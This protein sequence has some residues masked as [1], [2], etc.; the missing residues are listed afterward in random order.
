[1]VATWLL[2][3]RR[4][5]SATGS[6]PR[7]RS[8]TVRRVSFA[9]SHKMTIVVLG[10]GVVGSSIAYHLALAG[11]SCTIIEQERPAAG[12]SGKAGGFLAATW[13]DGRASE[14]LHRK[15]Y[16]MHAELAQRLN[17]Q[18]Y[19]K[20]KTFRVDYCRR[21]G[22]PVVP[23]LDADDA[24]ASLLDE[25]TAQV[26]PAELSAALLREALASGLCELRIGE[27]IGVEFDEQDGTAC[28]SVQLQ[29]GDEVACQSVVVAMGPWS[30]RVEDWFGVPLPLEGV[31]STSIVYEDVGALEPAALFVHEDMRG[32][33]LEI[34]P[35][36]C[37]DIYVSGCGGSRMVTADALRR[38]E[39][40]PAATNDPDM[41]RV[42]AAERSLAELT[43]KVNRPSDKQQACLRP[44]SPDG[45]PIMGRL[46]GMQNAYVAAG[47]NAWGILLAPITGLAM[48]QL[49]LEGESSVVNLKP[50]RPHRFNTLTHQTLMK[51]RGRQ[52]HGTEIG[53][54]W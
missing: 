21:N 49:L 48:S 38:G 28:V 19:R 4:G 52:R 32:C 44:C 42:R 13:G 34:Y 24:S 46:P 26:D 45:M 22:E 27:C 17:L 36:P 15:S 51:R 54:Q 47:H 29:G 23:W 39:V 11:A 33:H 9:R 25:E 1:M 7:I 12:A 37:G 5:W 2:V 3:C 6:C 16:A 43:S 8:T 31:W 53:E 40:S 20:V 10:G 35:R 14:I 50:F 18:S 30:C 41:S